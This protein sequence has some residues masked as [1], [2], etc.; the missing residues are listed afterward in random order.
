[1][2]ERHPFSPDQEPKD[3]A[4]KNQH[5]KQQRSHLSQGSH[6]Q[7]HLQPTHNLDHRYPQHPKNPAQ[8]PPHPNAPYNVGHNQVHVDPSYP[9][10]GQQHYPNTYGYNGTQPG[11]VQY[12]MPY[13]HVIPP[14]GNQTM[15]RG[16]IPVNPHQQQG[17]NHNWYR[18]RVNQVFIVSSELRIQDVENKAAVRTGLE[19][20]WG[21]LKENGAAQPLGPKVDFFVSVYKQILLTLTFIFTIVFAI[22]DGDKNIVFTV[23][24]TILTA[25]EFFI[26]LFAGFKFFRRMLCVKCVQKKVGPAADVEEKVISETEGASEQQEATKRVPVVEGA[27]AR[28]AQF[29]KNIAQEI[30][31]YPI[32]V[33]DLYGLV[34]EQSYSFGSWESVI[35]ML[36][37]IF[38]MIELIF[39]YSVRMYMLIVVFKIMEDKVDGIRQCGALCFGGIQW[40]YV[41]NIIGNV[42]VF[43]LMIAI[44]GIQIQVDNT[45]LGELH[46]S[47]AAGFMIACTILLP[48][49]NVAI[50]LAINMHAVMELLY[51]VDIHF[52][53]M[54]PGTREEFRVKH[55][56]F[57]Q[58]NPDGSHSF[59]D[60]DSAQKLPIYK[61]RLK[62]YQAVST[63][64]RFSFGLSNK[65]LAVALYIWTVFFSAYLLV[66]P[67]LYNYSASSG[68]LNE[69]SVG[70]L[71]IF[72]WIFFTLANAHAY[73]LGIIITAYVT[74]LITAFFMSCVCGEK[75]IACL[76]CTS[77]C[78][79]DDD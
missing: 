20:I 76:T 63:W 21:M 39:T 57:V 11:T 43:V 6:G 34:S 29:A 75:K 64:K 71:K 62:G 48:I 55:N 77:C 18:H 49:C 25:A 41:S 3:Q 9:P 10:A 27:G 24:C 40:R 26:W 79:N 19:Y 23:I 44:L 28:A 47:G 70:T 45:V 73:I 33:C 54:H 74:L 14:P 30:L 68:G 56:L 2:E 5:H 53:E 65:F 7:A 35:S 42:V 13:Q 12:S 37:L 4:P 32:I 67:G 51:K 38:A 52:A 78:N 31:L 15:D 50:F 22:L 8:G 1:M 72:L 58:K 36:L 46:V 61:E 17:Q 66:S 59:K 69:G 60:D 16:E